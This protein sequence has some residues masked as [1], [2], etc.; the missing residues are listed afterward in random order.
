MLPLPIR[1]FEILANRKPNIFLKE[2][3]DFSKSHTWKDV[4]RLLKSSGIVVDPYRT[5]RYSKLCKEALDFLLARYPQD[6]D[7][8][9]SL[10][11]EKLL[12]EKLF[13][14][15]DDEKRQLGLERI[16]KNNR[17]PAFI[18]ATEVLLSSMKEFGNGIPPSSI[19]ERYPFFVLTLDKSDN[20]VPADKV[21]AHLTLQI[22]ST[23]RR[24]TF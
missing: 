18:V 13:T 7:K 6:K 12:F 16:H 5:T 17:A 2:L 21:A 9:E 8:T 15:L 23:A 24:S 22:E 4:S 3:D 1:K 20:V 11:R 19:Q 14:L 10:I